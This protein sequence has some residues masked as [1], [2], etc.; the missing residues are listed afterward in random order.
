MSLEKLEETVIEGGGTADTSPKIIYITWDF[1]SDSIETPYTVYFTYKGEYFTSSTNLGRRYSIIKV[2]YDF[3]LGENE[4]PIWGHFKGDTG[5]GILDFA[6]KIENN[7]VIEIGEYSVCFYVSEEGYS[8]GSLNI[9][10]K[11][12]GNFNITPNIYRKDSITKS[13]TYRQNCKNIY[14]QKWNS[15]YFLKD[16]HSLQYLIKDD[17]E[18][19]ILSFNSLTSMKTMFIKAELAKM[20][21]DFVGKY[22][23]NYYICDFSKEILAYPS[24]IKIKIDPRGWS[25]QTQYT[26][27]YIFVVRKWDEDNYSNQWVDYDVYYRT[28]KD[29][30]DYTYLTKPANRYYSCLKQQDTWNITIEHTM[31]LTGCVG[32]VFGTSY[33]QTFIPV[34]DDQIMFSSD[35]FF[36]ENNSSL[37]SF[38]IPENLPKL[39]TCKEDFVYEAGK[40]KFSVDSSYVILKN[41]IS[42]MTFKKYKISKIEKYDGIRGYLNFYNSDDFI[43]QEYCNPTA[44][45]CDTYNPQKR[46][47]LGLIRNVEPNTLDI[48]YKYKITLASKGKIKVFRSNWSET[49]YTFLVSFNVNNDA[50]RFI[51]DVQAAGGS[52]ASTDKLIAVNRKYPNGGG[53]GGAFV[54]LLVN[55]E[56]GDLYIG[57]EKTYTANDDRD[58]KHYTWINY[59]TK[60]NEEIC[61]NLGNGGMGQLQ[62]VN[63]TN[64]LGGK[65]NFEPSVNPNTDIE[66]INNLTRCVE[67]FNHLY[68]NKVKIIN[69]YYGKPAPEGIKANNSVTGKFNGANGL[70]FKPQDTLNNLDGTT[71]QILHWFGSPRDYGRGKGGISQD[72]SESTGGGGGGASVLGFGLNGKTRSEQDN[73]AKGDETNGF[74]GGGG[75]GVSLKKGHPGPVTGFWG[76]HGCFI[77][78]W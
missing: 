35:N 8:K 3:I 71:T 59:I 41:F 9:K 17:K 60:N 7:K 72:A 22:Q 66:T 20:P 50:K 2:P 47:G 39:S 11:Y 34:D 58:S 38:S 37:Y 25:D 15:N 28:D 40:N 1:D 61:I 56:E 45:L 5:N 55:L 16:I 32:V 30:V 42:S 78:Y 62:S 53:G 48:S 23:N 68:E 63:L 49:N 26:W 70:S 29:T 43:L 52:G 57:L 44:I 74:G 13:E 64:G 18:Y 33:N 73:N 77:I 67:N 76:Q 12:N 75:G 31:N 65:I 10:Y 27:T 19:K 4:E 21:I 6:I 69:Y 46:W 14:L 36:S 24:R 54:R 51:I